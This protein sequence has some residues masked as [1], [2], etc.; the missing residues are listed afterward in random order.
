MVAK[1]PLSIKTKVLNEWLQGFTRNK[2]AENNGIGAGTV[3][4][5]HQQARNNDI[6]DIDL[7]R[8]LA[9]M[10][11]KKGLD[12]NHF[13]SSVRLKKVLDRIGFPEEK[14]ES[15]LEEIH[16]YSFQI[17]IDEKEFLSKT[18]EILQMAYEQIFRYQLSWK[19]LTKRQRSW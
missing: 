2:I 15:L 10:L 12:V 1:I 5:I 8:E 7:M 18:D 16:I 13:S 19:K 3:M 11:K 9:L 6:P 14:L 4:G 17:G